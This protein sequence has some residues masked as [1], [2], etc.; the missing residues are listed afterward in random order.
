MKKENKEKTKND[1][2]NRDFETTAQKKRNYK[3]MIT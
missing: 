3:K 1:A 2:K